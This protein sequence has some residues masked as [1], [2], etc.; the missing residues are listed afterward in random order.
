M[1]K[2]LLYTYD[3]EEENVQPRFTG[4]KQEFSGVVVLK[5]PI[6]PSKIKIIDNM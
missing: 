5:G 6:P 4:P 3:I 1:K 2:E